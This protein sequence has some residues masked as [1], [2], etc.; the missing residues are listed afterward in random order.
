M[1]FNIVQ[2]SVNIANKRILIDG[3]A[4]QSINQTVNVGTASS[5]STMQRYEITDAIVLASANNVTMV[6]NGDGLITLTIPD[7]T[8][9]MTIDITCVEADLNADRN[10]IIKIPI[11]A[12]CAQVSSRVPH[13]TFISTEI[14]H[15][16]NSG[17][18]TEDFPATYNYSK[19][20]HLV[21][22]LSVSVKIETIYDTNFIIK[23]TF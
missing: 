9:I 18:F 12:G 13:V 23:L 22:S 5:G 16:A 7:G 15:S 4:A 11:P 21:D 3:A 20:T 10:L 17:D 6:K 14:P 1:P 8:D 19:I 2:G